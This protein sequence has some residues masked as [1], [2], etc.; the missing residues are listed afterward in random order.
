MNVNLNLLLFLISI[1]FL[2]NNSFSNDCVFGECDGINEWVYDFDNQF[3]NDPTQGFLQSPANAWNLIERD[4]ETLF[5]GEGG[6]VFIEEAFR[7]DP[8]RF[9]GLVNQNPDLLDIPK[10]RELLE[11]R[12]E[13][14]VS[15]LNSNPELRAQFFEENGI[16]I[17][18]DVQISSFSSTNRIINLQTESGEVSISLNDLNG[19]AINSDGSVILDN[20]VQVF[21]GSIDRNQ[22]G[23]RF[24]EES[25]A[26]IQ[27]EEIFSSEGFQ[28]RD[29]GNGG[30]RVL[31]LED[32]FVE[33]DN[34]LRRFQGTNTF[35]NSGSVELGAQSRVEVFDDSQALLRRF[36]TEDSSMLFSNSQCSL[37]TNCVNERGNI[38]QISVT[39]DGTQ[40]GVEVFS[41]TPTQINVEPILGDSVVTVKKYGVQGDEFAEFTITQNNM[42]QST[43]SAP[44]EEDDSFELIYRTL[45]LENQEFLTHVLN[46]NPSG[47]TS[48]LYTS[49]DFARFEANSRCNVGEQCR[50]G[51][52]NYVRNEHG[53]YCSND[54]KCYNEYGL[55]VSEDGMAYVTGD[56]NSPEVIGLVNGFQGDESDLEASSQRESGVFLEGLP[57]QSPARGA[58]YR[59]ISEVTG[60]GPSSCSITGERDCFI[61]SNDGNRGAYYEKTEFGT[62]C[63]GDEKCYNENGDRVNRDGSQGNFGDESSIFQ[64]DGFWRQPNQA[65][66]AVNNRIME[67]DWAPAQ[68]E[69]N[70]GYSCQ[71]GIYGYE[72]I[73]V[74]GVRYFRARDGNLYDVNG[75]EFS[76][77][78]DDLVSTGGQ[79]S[80]V[81]FF[82]GGSQ[83]RTLTGNQGYINTNGEVYSGR[84]SE[85][86]QLLYQALH[87]AEWRGQVD[88]DENWRRNQVTTASS[89][90]GPVQITRDLARLY[91]NNRPELFTEEER[92]WISN[93]YIPMTSRMLS[94]S[95]SDS[96][97][98]LGGVGTLNSDYDR[99]MYERMA[100]AILEGHLSDSRGN[101][102]QAA[103]VWR[104][105][106]TRGVSGRYRA[107]INTVINS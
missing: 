106:D 2:S 61:G 72:P 64:D 15:L 86:A 65:V 40:F 52:F 1:L 41:N 75:N 83:S 89:A 73:E 81:D 13:T 44:L 22:F 102:M 70:S 79:S 54:E 39:D 105:G 28:I 57:T 63:S 90:Y 66:T 67:N 24:S 76:F 9:I 32:S 95:S 68:C 71:I 80:Q 11:Q 56:P 37:G 38:V 36:S 7:N 100:L 21:S 30:I 48:L 43:I 33:Y 29:V 26:I 25:R 94:S 4:F 17:E 58:V 20:G 5:R 97:Y 88:Y 99:Q 18:G 84:F 19:G 74:N 35:Y 46:S 31:S 92:E 10:V 103:S 62:F 53:M 16:N 69:L 96:V 98:G 42:V 27:S 82:S 107:E 77:I 50:I 60:W 45:D 8:N 49:E 93:T 101:M 34:G 12:L 23:Y 55:R 6:D 47:A 78:G 91:V 85:E 87:A 104:Y 51:R 14:D 59:E 3:Y